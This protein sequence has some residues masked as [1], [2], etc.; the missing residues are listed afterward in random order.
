VLRHT[1]KQR[2]RASL[3]AV[4]LALRR[5]MH[6]PLPAR[7]VAAIGSARVLRVPRGANQ[8]PYSRAIPNRGNALLAADA[9]A[10]Q[11]EESHHLGEDEPNCGTLASSTAN[12]A[13]V[14]RTAVSRQDPRQEPGAVVPHAGICAG[15]PG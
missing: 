8:C 4:K 6:D 3:Q 11:S 12:L 9:T 5:R 15:G 14:A 2:L 13:S 7:C 1:A 10:T